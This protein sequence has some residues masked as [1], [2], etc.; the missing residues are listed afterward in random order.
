[1]FLGK[2]RVGGFEPRNFQGLIVSGVSLWV[3]LFSVKKVIRVQGIEVFF[4]LESWVP[5]DFQ[6]VFL[7]LSM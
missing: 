1:M 2:S 5:G 6:S 7:A 4:R 3:Y